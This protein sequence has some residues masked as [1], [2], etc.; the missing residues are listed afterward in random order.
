MLSLLTVLMDLLI[1]P[2]AML[3]LLVGLIIGLSFWTSPWV[4]GACGL[5]CLFAGWRWERYDQ[6]DE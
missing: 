3:G 2:R 1:L 6:Q 4:I 5:A